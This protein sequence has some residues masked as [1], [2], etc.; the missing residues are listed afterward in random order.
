MVRPSEIHWAEVHCSTQIH[1]NPVDHLEIM[2]RM[3]DGLWP[4]YL[5][6]LQSK[7]QRYKEDKVPKSLA[8]LHD[9]LGKAPKGFQAV[10]AFMIE[11]TN[12]LAEIINLSQ[13]TT[14]PVAPVFYDRL[15]DLLQ[16]FQDKVA[17]GNYHPRVETAVGLLRESNKAHY[18]AVFKMPTSPVWRN[19]RHTLMVMLH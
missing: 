8:G 18:Y 5:T 9:L 16:Y 3:V 7:K 12:P 13:M 11:E 10:L 6:F 19:W 1:K 14:V 17:K 2:C 15:Q 4:A